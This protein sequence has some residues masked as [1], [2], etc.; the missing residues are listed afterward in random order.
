MPKI[1]KLENKTYDRLVKEGYI[2]FPPGTRFLKEEGA[3]DFGPAEPLLLTTDPSITGKPVMDKKASR[4]GKP[5][6]RS[7]LST[8]QQESP[9]NTHESVRIKDKHPLADFQI[10]TPQPGSDDSRV[11][12]LGQFTCENGTLREA[13]EDV[14]MKAFAPVG[15][16]SAERNNV[17]ELIEFISTL[18][19]HPH[20][21]QILN[22]L[23]SSNEV[24]GKP[25]GEVKEQ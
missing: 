25:E 3:I 1:Q 16:S 10:S 23:K 22:I 18:P 19:D 14:L 20:R 6:V 15:V 2:I 24:Q 4:V 8:N 5:S 9:E 17:A 13:V 7:S 12:R 21:T 11:V